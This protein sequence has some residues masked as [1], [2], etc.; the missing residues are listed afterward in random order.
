MDLMT[1]GFLKLILK[2]IWL[3]KVKKKSYSG[4]KELKKTNGTKD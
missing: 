2:N 4:L 3:S 1:T